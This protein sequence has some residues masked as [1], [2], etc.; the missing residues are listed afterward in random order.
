MWEF[1]IKSGCGINP[2]GAA[3]AQYPVKIVGEDVLV[4]VVGVE[5]KY[6]RP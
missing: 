2:T 6:A 5:P 4:S 3:L 1:D